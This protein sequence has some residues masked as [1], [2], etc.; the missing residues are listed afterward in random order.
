MMPSHGSG[1]GPSATLTEKSAVGSGRDRGG[2]SC[3]ARKMWFA[4]AVAVFMQFQESFVVL[5]A[6]S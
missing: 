2:G 4:I 3:L 6:C 1:N 5:S